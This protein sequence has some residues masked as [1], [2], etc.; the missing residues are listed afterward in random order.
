MLLF[1]L[2]SITYTCLIMILQPIITFA[3]PLGG[4]NKEFYVSVENKELI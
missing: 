1:Q 4:T 2:F 3:T